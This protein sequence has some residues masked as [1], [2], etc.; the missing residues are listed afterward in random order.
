MS[1]IITNPKIAKN[2]GFYDGRGRYYLIFVNHNPVLTFI[3]CSNQQSVAFNII[4]LCRVKPMATDIATIPPA[5]IAVAVSGVQTRSFPCDQ[6]QEEQEERTLLLREPQLY[7]HPLPP[8]AAKAPTAV[9]ITMLS[10]EQPILHSLPPKLISPPA[11]S[12]EELID[13]TV[14]RMA[15]IDD[16]AITSEEQVPSCVPT[17]SMLLQQQEEESQLQRMPQRSAPIR[18]PLLNF[19]DMKALMSSGL[20]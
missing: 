12:L 1:L 11:I 8:Q 20:V 9:T 19:S 15:E 17:V 13:S 3:A 6:D 5:A 7:L 10:Q 14:R 16:A 4:I 2:I 18:T